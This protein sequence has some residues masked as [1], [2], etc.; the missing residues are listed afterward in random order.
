MA[1]KK[2][3]LPFIFFLVPLLVSAQ[4]E[5]KISITLSGGVFTT[6]G[7]KDY[8]PDY[9]SSPEDREPFQ[10]SNY[11]PG[12]VTTFGIQ[13]NLNRHLSFQVDVSIMYSGGWSYDIGEGNYTE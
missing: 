1:M 12:F 5:Q 11:L 3:I 8:M 7:A 6:I 2:W 13:Y 10:M 4:F 9:G